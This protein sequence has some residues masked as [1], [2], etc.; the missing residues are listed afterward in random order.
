MSR[1]KFILSPSEVVVGTTGG[2]CWEEEAMVLFDGR[3]GDFDEG[4]GG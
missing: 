3:G 1:T 2:R 4:E